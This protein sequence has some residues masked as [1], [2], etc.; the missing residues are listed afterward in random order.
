MYTQKIYQSPAS[1]E[2]PVYADTAMSKQI[3]KLFAGSSCV[4]IGEEDDLAI[5]MFKIATN[6][7]VY[8][9]GFANAAGICEE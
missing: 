2:T 6:P 5:V 3:G 1:G 8:K 9:V 7:C 4:C